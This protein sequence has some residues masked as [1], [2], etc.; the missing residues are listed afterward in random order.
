VMVG[1]SEAVGIISQ[2]S[3][4]KAGSL[5]TL[6]WLRTE[7]GRNSLGAENSLIQVVSSEEPSSYATIQPSLKGTVGLSVI[8]GSSLL[9]GSFGAN[10]LQQFE[11]DGVSLT[12]GGKYP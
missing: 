11:F 3:F 10:Q 7:Q 1:G 6:G 2:F 9:T 12:E 8:S 5:C 4:V